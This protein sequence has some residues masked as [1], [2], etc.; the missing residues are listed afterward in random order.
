MA[1]KLHKVGITSSELL[2][3]ICYINGV[4]MLNHTVKVNGVLYPWTKRIELLREAHD[5]FE[6]E[7]LQ[8]KNFVPGF[9]GEYQW[10]DYFM[11]Q[12][13]DVIYPF[14]GHNLRLSKHL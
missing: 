10:N 1:K 4:T 12:V 6:L 2:N 5:Q 3:V 9:H 13:F 11:G 7:G 14:L 8:W